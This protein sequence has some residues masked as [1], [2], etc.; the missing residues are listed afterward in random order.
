MIKFWK[1]ILFCFFF[2][3]IFCVLPVQGG[4]ELKLGVIPYKTP[5]VVRELHLPLASHLSD[6]LGVNVR[7]L[8]ARSFEEYMEYVY[9]RKYDIIVLGS[10]FYFKAH[11]K[12]GYQAIA[13]GYPSFHAGIIVL[14]SSGVT[15]LEQLKGKS[16]AAVTKIG[17]GGYKLQKRA[18]LK[19]GVDP[20]KD[21]TVTFKG[22]N[23]SVIFSVLDGEHVAG[24][25][26]LDTL[27]RPLYAKIKDTLRFV[28][29]SPKIWQF[30]FAVRADMDQALRQKIVK[31]LSSL[32]MEQP[33][34]AAMLKDFHLKGI[35][36]VNHDDM[37]RLRKKRQ[38]ETKK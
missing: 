1:K 4:N 5:R 7:V 12:A 22:D 17:R 27:Q 13:R 16:L 6:A 32:S 36:E 8:T 11:D 29:T 19:K 31:A 28:Y 3:S 35:K 33:E 14:R 38:Q 2:I 9:D 15:R 25:I 23:D 26:R 37:E 34:T 20:E 24:A 30:P 21:M 10:S 18:L